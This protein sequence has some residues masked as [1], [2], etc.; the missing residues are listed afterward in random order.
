MINNKLLLNLFQPKQYQGWTL[1]EMGAVSVVVGILAAM[2]F[3]SM[4]GMMARNDLRSDFDEVKAAIQE[5]QRNAIKRGASCVVTIASSGISASPAGC[6]N[7]VPS[8]STG[9]TISTV[10]YGTP[11]TIEFS[12]KG[13]PTMTGTVD[14]DRFL[15]M[16]K[17]GT[18]DRKCLVISEGIGIM[19]GGNW[20]GTNCTT[21]L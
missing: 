8:L 13:N 3:P 10:G 20:D 7:S 17:T 18:P 12:Y 4:S 21:S 11:A 16:A 1:I 14:T 2:A 6:I 19:R 15:I 5:A 9:T